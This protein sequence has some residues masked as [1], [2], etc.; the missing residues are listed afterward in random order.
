MWLLKSK[1]TETVYNY[2]IF[3]I[4]V[5]KKISMM[6]KVIYEKAIHILNETPITKF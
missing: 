2:Y 1:G 6:R 3:T 5:M 4:F